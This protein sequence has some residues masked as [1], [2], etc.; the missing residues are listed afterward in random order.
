TLN[1]Q[2]AF[3]GAV[4]W[5]LRGVEKSGSSFAPIVITGSTETSQDV[6]FIG[7]AS[8][9]TIP[10]VDAPAGLVGLLSQGSFDSASAGDKRSL[11]GAAVVA[12][13]PLSN[14]SSTVP[15]IACHVSTVVSAAR[16]RSA[17]ISLSS[18]EGGYT[19]TYDLSVAA[20]KSMTAERTLRALG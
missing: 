3:A 12:E 8:Y 18:I 10:E 2:L 17:G 13:N 19:S 6:F 11:L 16:A 14:A 7:D 4:R 9:E 20:G 1:A 5:T 15:C